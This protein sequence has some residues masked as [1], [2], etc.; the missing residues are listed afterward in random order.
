MQSVAVVSSDGECSLLHSH[1]RSQQPTCSSSL[2]S[3]SWF[4]ACSAEFGSVCVF[5]QLD[6]IINCFQ[7][8]WSAMVKTSKNQER[9]L[10]TAVQTLLTARGV[11]QVTDSLDQPLDR[12]LTSSPS[13]GE[14]WIPQM[15]AIRL[16]FTLTAT[17]FAVCDDGVCSPLP[18]PRLA[19]STLDIS[20]AYLITENRSGRSRWLGS[21]SFLPSSMRFCA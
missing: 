2:I 11:M 21:S 15:E 9:G 19:G 12:A 10:S 20:S 14:D 7:A 13:V 18:Q 1:S 3:A 5:H 6:S 4:D 8:I 16:P 17:G